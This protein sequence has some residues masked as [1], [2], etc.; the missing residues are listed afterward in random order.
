MGK[1]NT[2]PTC[3]CPLLYLW[4]LVAATNDAILLYQQSSK[5]SVCFW[6]KYIHGIN[7]QSSTKSYTMVQSGANK[8]FYCLRKTFWD[9]LSHI[10][11]KGDNDFAAINRICAILKL[12]EIGTSHLKSMRDDF[13]LLRGAHSNLL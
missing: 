12:K 3:F 9:V 13:K 2:L 6:S 11:C 1:M 10:F 8:V 4:L 5:G 7:G